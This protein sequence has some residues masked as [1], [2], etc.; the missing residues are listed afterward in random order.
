[1]AINIPGLGGE[2]GG[3]ESFMKGTE[4][5]VVSLRGV[6]YRFWSHLEWQIFLA[7]KV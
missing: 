3:E 5:F 6:N 2:G 7:V 1:M 4:V